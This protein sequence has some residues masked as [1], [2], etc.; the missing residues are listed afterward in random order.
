M[1][2]I[3]LTMNEQSKYDII[4]SF[5]DNNSSNFKQL[6][7]KLNSSLKTAYNLV[8]KYKQFG[9]EAFRHKNHDHKPIH[10]IDSET[11]SKIIDIYSN[12][13]ININFS[14]FK[15]ILMRDYN[16]NVSRSVVYNILRSADF[17]SPKSRKATIKKR[18]DLIKLKLLNKQTLTTNEQ[19]IV[20]N[21]LLDS[22]IAHP[23]KERSKYF[24]ELVQMDASQHIWFGNSK[25]H[26]HAAIDDST[27]R[28]LGLFFDKQETL[29]GY[30]QVTKQI[31]SNY[32][33]PAQILTDNR[34]VFNYIKSGKTSLERDTF[35]QYGFM[36]HRL[37]IALH[38]SSTPEVKGRIERL[39]QTLQSRLIVEM[40]LKGIESVEQANEFIKSYQKEFNDQFSLPYNH[41]VDA[42]EK[43][44]DYDKIN[45]VLATV[46]RR[47]TDNG[48]CI[49]YNNKYYKFYKDD[50]S[51]VVPKPKTN[52]LI[53]KKFDGQLI[54]L[55]N[56]FAYILEEFQI[57]REDSI[58]ELPVKKERKVYRPPL[59]HP[60]KEQSYL[61][62]LKNYRPN[63]QNNYSYNI[64]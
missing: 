9:K 51:Q 29:Y 1:K 12:M 59:S 28:I 55:I 7:I 16:I 41:T 56:Q 15:D 30:Y 31:L 35:T 38:T 33:I 50:G 54:C 37:G 24:G 52:C 18:N 53:I 6:S 10:T 43:Q 57:H 4:K 62:Y 26:L 3:T 49:K 48:G 5:V 19:A 42:F 40:R 63:M 23:R 46:S 44:I 64:A 45:E 34:T 17:Y 25:Y 14:H 58:L 47:K 36:C 2:G 39:F 8:N 61:N 13:G 11:R 22:S 21:N 27:G 20:S 32:G 60:F